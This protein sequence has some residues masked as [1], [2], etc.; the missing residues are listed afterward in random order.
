MCTI[1]NNKKIVIVQHSDEYRNISE[2]LPFLLHIS[3]LCSC[4][5]LGKERK[6]RLGANHRSVLFCMELVIVGKTLCFPKFCSFQRRVA[7]WCHHKDQCAQVLLC[8]VFTY[9]AEQKLLC[10]YGTCHF[11]RTK[12]SYQW[13]L[14]QDTWWQ[15]GVDRNLDKKELMHILQSWDKWLQKSW[16]LW[17][18]SLSKKTK[19][20]EL[21]QMLPW[22]LQELHRLPRWLNK[23]PRLQHWQVLILEKQRY[24]SQ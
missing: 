7:F 14:L 1:N 5:F 8:Y 2:L 22:V 9:R 23:D 11:T 19:M 13:Q 15:L 3:I 6:P 24:L 20:L 16:A 12:K 17:Q 21:G 18:V 10:N 4:I